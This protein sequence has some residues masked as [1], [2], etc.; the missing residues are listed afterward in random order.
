[1]LNIPTSSASPVTTTFSLAETLKIVKLRKREG[2]HDRLT[3]LERPEPTNIDPEHN[4][5]QDQGPPLNFH[6]IAQ[7]LESDLNSEFDIPAEDVAKHYSRLR[8]KY[9]CH[10]DEIVDFL[11]RCKEATS[12]PTGA[13]TSFGVSLKPFLRLGFLRTDLRLGLRVRPLVMYRDDHYTLDPHMTPIGSRKRVKKGR[14]H[15][16]VGLTVEPLVTHQAHHLTI[17]GEEVIMIL[18][19]GILCTIQGLGL[20]VGPLVIHQGHQDT[21]DP[22]INPIV[23]LRRVRKWCRVLGHGLTVGPLVKHQ[24]Y[25]DTPYP[26]IT[27]IMSLRGVKQ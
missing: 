10:Y 27:S 19:L 13:G 4:L 6:R 17:Q 22:D 1:M 21:P 2:W 7:I 9:D 3:A 16:G 14:Q 23:S 24:D 12:Q 18:W 26:H 11:E 5:P 15:L 25:Q 20:T 8:R